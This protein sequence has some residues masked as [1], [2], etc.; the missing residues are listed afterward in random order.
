M[1]SLHEMGR[2]AE[3]IVRPVSWWLTELLEGR[4][5]MD[6]VPASVRSWSSFFVHRAALGIV[7]LGSREERLERLDQAPPRMRPYVEEEIARLWPL[8]KQLRKA[9]ENPSG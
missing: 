3:G 2:D 4:K 6:E 1:G 8:R 7:L 5:G 9:K